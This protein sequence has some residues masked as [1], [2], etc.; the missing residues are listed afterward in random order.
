MKKAADLQLIQ[1]R[2]GKWAVRKRGGGLLGGEEKLKFLAENG[3]IK[4]PT[5]KKVETPAEEA[6]AEDAPAAEAA[7]PEAKADA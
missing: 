1:K 7:A 3:K 2:N 6:P 4:L 5:P